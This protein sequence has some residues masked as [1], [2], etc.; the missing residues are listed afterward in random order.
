MLDGRVARYEW[1]TLGSAYAMSEIQAASCWP[2]S[3]DRSAS[4]SAGRWSTHERL[5]PLERKARGCPTFR[6][7]RSSDH[8]STLLP[9]G[10]SARAFGVTSSSEVSPR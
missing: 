4:R 7:C 9:S 10:R 5:E 1:V 8:C 6:H 3:E 2:S